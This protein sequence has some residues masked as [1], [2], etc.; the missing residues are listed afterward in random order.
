VSMREF[1][2]P[3]VVTGAALGL[4]FAASSLYLVLKIGMTV[5]ASIPVAVLAI[6]LFKAFSKVTG[7]RKATILENNVTQTAGSAGES[8]AFGVGVT[9]PALMMLGFHMDLARVMVVSV[10]GGLL[11]I[12]AMIP[13]RRAFIVK[14][15]GKPGQ[16]GTLLFPEGTACAQVLISGEK[17]GS[18]GK[19][20]FFGFGLAFLH[21]LVVEGMFLLS[22]VVKFPFT[23]INKTAEFAQD[24]ASELL[25]VGYIIGLRTSAMMMGGAV[26]GYL[27]IIPMI[28]FIGEHSDTV[29]PPGEKLI[30][31]MSV[32]DIRNAYLLYVGA[33]CVA[34]AGIISM[35][36]TMP[37]IVRGLIASVRGAKG[38]PVAAG[39]VKRTDNDMS[40]KVVLF[41]SLGLV[42][43]LTIF[44]A[45][46][47]D[48][49][50]AVLGAGLVVVFGF[51][52]VTVSSRLTGEIGSSSNP[53]SGMT[54]ATLML[55]CLLFVSLGM[56][57]VEERVLALCVAAVVCVA[58][59]N[60][61]STAQS[62]KTGF[63]VGGTPKAG[64]YAIL[65][66]ALTSALVI[67][68]TLILLNES[69]TIY[70][71]RP[72]LLPAVTLTPAEVGRLKQTERYEG[73]EY[74]AFDTRNE[75]L[76][77]PAGDYVPRPEVAAA[78]EGRY[79]VERETG[80]IRYL[81]DPTILGK[82][83]ARDDGT[84]V[85]RIDAPK[86]QLMSI[87]INGVLK[88]ELNWSMVG[89]GAMIALMLELCGVSALAFAVGLYVP[90]SVS[91][92]IFLGGIV[93]WLVDKKFAR[94][95]AAAMAAAG[96]D[97]EKKAAAEVETL[98][99]TETSGGVLLASG[100]I[101][102]GS[103]A[104]MLL[105]FMAFSENW[106]GD[107]GQYQYGKVPF[108]Q[109]ATLEQAAD[110]YAQQ[111]LGYD[112]AA[113][114]AE[115]T[116]DN[117]A[118]FE[119]I[120]LQVKP[121]DLRLGRLGVM[122]RQADKKPKVAEQPPTLTPTEKK[123]AEL[124]ALRD[125]VIELSADETY[126]W[127]T[128]KA[129]TVLKVPGVEPITAPATVTIGQIANDLFHDPKPDTAKQI[130]EL[131]TLTLG[132][133]EGADPLTVPVPAGTEIRVPK[134]LVVETDT[135]LPALAS[136]VLGRERYAPRLF[137]A[138]ATVLELPKELPAA[139]R[140]TKPQSDWPSIMAFVGLM[141]IL[142]VVG[143]RA[144]KEE[145][146]ETR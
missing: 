30:K 54:I 113:L 97:P 82:L 7:L 129:G 59:S 11:G 20:V 37:M 56:T 4:V 125:E 128:V 65:V 58:S 50:K 114:E 124:N 63:L 132:V 83:D 57:S 35:L 41:G 127:V 118:A 61:G 121:G 143:L 51:L 133:K 80:K 78:K 43:L 34:T 140:L 123:L 116:H 12:L 108:G 69:K 46:Q 52:F 26:L 93:R 146:P 39:P 88:Q 105:A 100:Y 66:G 89:L 27:V 23:F 44:L 136:Q 32:K 60:G 74:A 77:K 6:T 142:L 5:S 64:Q 25:G 107:L 130:A 36:K 13:L 87:I 62:L 48:P 91:S 117:L 33:G 84:P 40:M 120:A 9:M 17:G 71:Q 79:L 67:G 85:T 104:G 92:P 103:I 8:I 102:G 144:A 73:A 115:V 90:I 109:V 122:V 15:H 81:K 110:T 70:S 111:T 101:A 53:I 31:D 141:V 21:K 134:R 10:L 138:N 3:A 45:Q 29:V 75:E 72:D 2:I 42:G 55:T 96:D 14:M 112:R 119:K 86:T 106:P 24:M 131:N 1:T 126:Q 135:P 38:G 68:G 18:A 22:A 139:A 95:G 47:V 145:E 19:L 16:P 76:T 137:K 99:K 98:R 94:E 49:V 28:F